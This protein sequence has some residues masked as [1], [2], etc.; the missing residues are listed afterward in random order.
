MGIDATTIVATTDNRG[1]AGWLR[2][3]NISGSAMLGMDAV[4]ANSQW[5]VLETFVAK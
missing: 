2:T 3:L 5:K 4:P 1:G